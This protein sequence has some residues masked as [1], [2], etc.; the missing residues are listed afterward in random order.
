MVTIFP[1]YMRCLTISKNKMY[2]MSGKERSSAVLK[3]LNAQGTRSDAFGYL[4]N[5]FYKT[6]RTIGTVFS[7]LKNRLENIY[8]TPFK[9]FIIF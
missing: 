5:T 7:S 9:N 1:P 3:Y 4:Y 2:S 8:K 6:E